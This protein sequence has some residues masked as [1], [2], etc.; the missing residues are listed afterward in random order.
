MGRRPRPNR[1]D[2]VGRAKA[3]LGWLLTRAYGTLVAS[4]PAPRISFERQ[5]PNLGG[6]G[7]PS[8]APQAEEDFEDDDV[9]AAVGHVSET[10]TLLTSV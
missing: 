7:A 6:R 4:N 2:F 5:E 10:Q 3:R 1:R 9:D 8:L